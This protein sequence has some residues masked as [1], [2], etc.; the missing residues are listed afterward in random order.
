MTSLLLFVLGSVFTPR[1]EVLVL[2]PGR[3]DYLL[4]YPHVVQGSLVVEGF[5]SPWRLQGDTL[6]TESPVSETLAVKVS[7]LTLERDVTN[8]FRIFTPGREPGFQ[9]STT[10]RGSVSGLSDNLKIH[11]AK[12][13]S[14][15]VNN[16]GTSDIDQGLVLDVEGQLAEV[17]VRTHLAD[18]QGSFVPSGTTERIED[19]DRIA[20]ELSQE[21]WKLGLGDLDFSYPVLG[22]GEIERRIQGTTGELNYK[23]FQARG[24]LGLE[25]TRRAHVIL[26]PR[27][28]KRG[29]YLVGSRFSEQP[30]IPGSERVWL[31]GVLLER[32][33]ELDYT[34]EYSTG[35]LFFTNRTPV[36]ANSRI[37]VDY[38]YAGSDYRSNNQLV[39]T[40]YGSFDVFFY[41]EADSRTHQFHTWSGEQQAVLDTAKTAEVILPGA[42]FVGEGK[43]SY[44]SENGHYVWAGFSQGDYDV[45]FRRVESGGDYIL[46]ADSGFYRYRGP[47]A[48]D[49][50]AEILTIL[51]RREEALGV[52]FNHEI[53]QISV[54]AAALGS[55]LTTNLYN[56]ASYSFGHAHKLSLGWEQEKLSLT[57]SHRL[58]LPGSWIP[59]DG[60]DVD[61]RD[62]WNLDSLPESLNEQGLS[63]S[64]L[65]VD[66]LKLTVEGGH[67]WST[68]H[69]FRAALSSQ[70]KFFNISGDWLAERQRARGEIHPRIGVFIPKAGASFQNFKAAARR[71]FEPLVGLRVEP[72]N[73]WWIEASASRRIDQ[74]L[75]LAWQDTLYYDRLALRGDWSADKLTVSATAG[76]ERYLPRG[77][78]G[79]SSWNAFFGDLRTYWFPNSRVRINADFSQHIVQTRQEV[80]EYVPV[81]P[82]T[83]DFKRDPETGE[84]IPAEKGD[85]KQEV[86]FR[87]DAGLAVE[88]NASLGADLKFNPVALWTTFIYED[89]VSSRSFITNGRIT[90]LPYY[91][92]LTVIVASSYTNQYLPSWGIS[93]ERL[94]SWETS[95][96]LRSRVHPD[97]LLR[98]EGSAKLQDRYRAETH[99]RSREEYETRLSPILELWLTLE[100]EIGFARLMA[101]EPLYYPQLGEI[102]IRRVWVGTDAEKQLGLWRITAGTAVTSRQSNVAR[103]DLPYLITQDDPPGLE[104]SWHFGLERSFTISGENLSLRTRYRGKLY[105]DERGLENTFE[106]SAGM[107]F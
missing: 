99:V 87:E 66:S 44:F 74:N 100:P 4:A 77:V 81:E 27:D 57:I 94:S 43:G 106:L 73:N 80:V 83:G 90:L 64:I 42:R 12:T 59:A 35:E 3:G 18:E 31:D 51:P 107:Y 88:R 105:P 21:K 19:F 75:T 101:E 49:Y 67:L 98:L 95:A 14:L 68:E 71:S 28:G 41:R 37:E 53:G 63:L 26:S 24:A 40:R 93:Q 72:G 76:L 85:Y 60:T 6:V 56:P 48:G 65:P 30:L 82:G 46:D 15:E 86:S 55:R 1:E 36:D 92:P 38:T 33:S 62:R 45:S 91:R 34:I 7:Y 5:N 32:G 10:S 84:Y 9:D 8:E 13:F 16:K 89:A 47:D 39:A 54:N 96:E 52:S 103:E 97:Y 25:G 23:K 20:V 2:E 29:P 102:T 58:K 22:Y 70:A 11:G 17:N 104:P 79:D 50:R 61:V 69:R 78:S